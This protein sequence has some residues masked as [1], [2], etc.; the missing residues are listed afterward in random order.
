MHYNIINTLS[1]YLLI[2]N[3]STEFCTSCVVVNPF[4]SKF[5]KTD[6]I[7]SNKCNNKICISDLRLNEV[8]QQSLGNRYVIGSSKILPLT[9]E[10]N[11]Y[12]DPAYLPK[13]HVEI[14][15][16]VRFSIIPSNCVTAENLS[17]NYLLCDFNNGNPFE[18]GNSVVFNVS[19]DATTFNGET[20]AIK[21]NVFDV[22]KN[23][24]THKNTFVN[25]ITL[26]E[27]SEVSISKKSSKISVSF[28]DEPHI[29]NVNQV[30]EVSI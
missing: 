24:N 1:A 18:N 14:P 16:A 20:I 2:S 28:V 29:Q 3:S 21:A 19:L 8:L 26:I 23:L 12:G 17:S 22:G 13:I 30:F 6:I 9:Y 25:N 27:F 7:F 15:N 10:I 4:D 11:N 5:I